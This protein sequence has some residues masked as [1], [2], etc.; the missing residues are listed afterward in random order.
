MRWTPIIVDVAIT[1]IV[2]AAVL[3]FL[4]Q[5]RARMAVTASPEARRSRRLHEVAAIAAMIG[6]TCL[7]A[8]FM[9]DAI[10]AHWLHALSAPAALT[11]LAVGAVVAGYAGWLGG[12]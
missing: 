8:W 3:G 11:F 9:T 5:R 12:F 10:G 6:V 1:V 4:R 2:W 7:L